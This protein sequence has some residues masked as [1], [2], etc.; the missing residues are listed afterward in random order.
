MQ[1]SVNVGLRRRYVI[2]WFGGDP[3]EAARRLFADVLAHFGHVDVLV[4]N[5]G[6]TRDNVF[7]RMKDAEWD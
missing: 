1:L 7:L 6:V 3:A 4:N 5:A 2:G